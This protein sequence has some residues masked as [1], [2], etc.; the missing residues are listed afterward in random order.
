MKNN[1][2]SCHKESERC[3]VY[4][5]QSTVYFEKIANINVGYDSVIP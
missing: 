2:E 4:P 1:N 3:A 5:E